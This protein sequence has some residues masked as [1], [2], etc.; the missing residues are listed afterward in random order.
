SGGLVD[1]VHLVGKLGNGLVLLCNLLPRGGQ[2]LPDGAVLDSEVIDV[3]LHGVNLPAKLGE[4]GIDGR[5]SGLHCCRGWG[6][7]MLRRLAVFA[8]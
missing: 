4:S 7:G 2:L 6:R 1:S 3:P 5:K 8:N